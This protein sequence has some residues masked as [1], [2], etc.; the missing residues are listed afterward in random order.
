MFVCINVI[1]SKY[2]FPIFILPDLEYLFWY[3]NVCY[4]SKDSEMIEVLKAVY[5]GFSKVILFTNLK[6]SIF[7]VINVDYYISS[8]I[9]WKV[10][11]D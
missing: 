10:V 8:D 4:I 2:I 11:L 6:Q 3:I 1:T 9:N 7:Q 5:S